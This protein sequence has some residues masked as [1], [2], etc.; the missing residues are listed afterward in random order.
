MGNGNGG[1]WGDYLNMAKSI[2]SLDEESPYLPES[3]TATRDYMEKSLL[4]GGEMYGDTA[5]PE[6]DRFRHVMGMRRSAMDPNV[7]ANAAWFGGLGHELNNLR[8]SILGGDI[9]QLGSPAKRLGLMQILQNS[10][11]DVVNNFIGILSS[12]TN[13]EELTDDQLQEILSWARL[14][15]DLRRPDESAVMIQNEVNGKPG[16]Q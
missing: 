6:A 8:K 3:L 1:G 9:S 7:G 5:S 10:A 15:R 13:P 14:P 4:E 16:R 2:F 11:D 12:Y